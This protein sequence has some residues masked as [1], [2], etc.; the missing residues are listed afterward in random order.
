MPKFDEDEWDDFDESPKK[1]E[2][3]LPTYVEEVV[4]EDGSDEKKG[5]INVAFIGYEHSGKSILYTLSGYW[6]QKWWTTSTAK[7]GGHIRIDKYPKCKQI[8]KEGILP[9]IELVQVIDLDCSYASLSKIGIFG[10][11]ARPL[12]KNKIIKSV[13]IPIPQ[14]QAALINNRI[15]E[16]SLQ[17]FDITKQKI[18][19]EISKAVEDNPETTALALDSMTSL[20]ELLNNKF[21]VLYEVA[22]A[23][24]DRGKKKGKDYY[25]S[26][27]DGIKQ[28]YWKIRNGWWVST[29]R[30][31]RQYKGWQFDTYKVEPKHPVWLKK[32]RETAEDEGKDVNKVKDY[33][34][35]WAPKTKF[36]L[37][38]I[39]WLENNGKKG[40]NA[41]YWAKIKNRFEGSSIMDDEFH[42]QVRYTPRKVC[43]FYDLMEQLA[44]SILG[45]VEKPDGTYEDDDIFGESVIFK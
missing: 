37:D 1:K 41:D 27:L 7:Q 18:D 39:L 12:Y 16:I 14:R 5:N 35:E 38:I 6:N 9:E 31:K 19:N 44:P 25:G 24:Q 43:A 28:S 17:N 40:E 4:Y 42:R 11:L 3:K 23:P 26:S 2:E 32:E 8:I 29:L 22:L 21:R 20:D 33:K 13:G 36:D 15:K 45:E 34:I 10:K 30:T